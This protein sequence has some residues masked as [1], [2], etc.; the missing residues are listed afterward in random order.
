MT[1]TTQ[2]RVL[3]KIEERVRATGFLLVIDPEWANRG[4]L[5]ATD[6][7]DPVGCG[8]LAY[9]FQKGQRATFKYPGTS[10][11]AFGYSPGGGTA[12]W[13]VPTIDQLVRDVADYLT[14]TASL[15]PER[16][17]DPDGCENPSCPCHDLTEPTV[18]R[19]DRP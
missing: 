18:N 2:T 12:T 14:G 11:Y 9:D 17:N 1:P 6:D 8:P 5:Y 3:A 4:T 15:D 13:C 7:L 19:E 10:E 16:C